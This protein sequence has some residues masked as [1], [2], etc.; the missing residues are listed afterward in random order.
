MRRLA[1]R[2]LGNHMFRKSLCSENISEEFQG[3]DAIVTGPD[4]GDTVY[5]NWLRPYEGPG[6]LIS[7]QIDSSVAVNPDTAVETLSLIF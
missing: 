7:L 4:G 5:Y 3:L 6:Y 2:F 1:S